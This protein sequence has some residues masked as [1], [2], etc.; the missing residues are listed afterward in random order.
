MISCLIL[1]VLDGKLKR[2]ML[3]C[4][5]ALIVALVI[6]DFI[7]DR[8]YGY[9]LSVIFQ[10][11]FVFAVVLTIML[12][13]LSAVKR[14][15]EATNKQLLRTAQTDEL[16]EAF[17]SRY[18]NK[19]LIELEQ[20]YQRNG[21]DFCVAILDID[22][23]KKI[24]D[25]YGHLYGDI[26]IK[27]LADC[28]RNATD[29]KVQLGRYGGDEFV[30]IFFDADKQTAY[31]ICEKVRKQIDNEQ[32]SDKKIHSTISMGVCKRSEIQE[33][34]DILSKIDQLLYESKRGGKNKVSYR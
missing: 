25:T 20:Q 22:D 17:N 31:E 5:L 28:I 10:R 6:G 4:Y 1:I 27:H 18:L 33:G 11:A 30:L 24:N 3:G 26:V 2:V 14:Q 34:E 8:F 29:E 13:V 32:I 16:S 9:P 12:L 7:A 23:F 15:M 19:K 21:D